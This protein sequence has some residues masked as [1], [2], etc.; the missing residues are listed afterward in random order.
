MTSLSFFLFFFPFFV[1]IFIYLFELD[2][3]EVS[4]KYFDMF[5]KKQNKKLGKSSFIKLGAKSMPQVYILT[6]LM[7]T[8]FSNSIFLFFNTLVFFLVLYFVAYSQPSVSA[9]LLLFSTRSSQSDRYPLNIFPMSATLCD[10][11]PYL[12]TW[13]HINTL[14]VSPLPSC[15]NILCKFEPSLLQ[16]SSLPLSDWLAFTSLATLD[17][18]WF[19]LFT[20]TGTNTLNYFKKL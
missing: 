1:F 20:I 2:Y 11:K 16:A 17:G 12:R 4:M 6:E 15:L 14:L 19:I 18:Q 8:L 9:W 13:F 7:G 3:Y 5:L 10:S